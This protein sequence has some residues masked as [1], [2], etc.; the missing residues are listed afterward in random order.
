MDAMKEMSMRAPKAKNISESE[1]MG[2]ASYTI[3]PMPRYDK[4]ALRERPMDYRGTPER[5]FDY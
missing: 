1:A 3:D 5:A 2:K 4:G